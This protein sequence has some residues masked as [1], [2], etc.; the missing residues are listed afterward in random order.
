ASDEIGILAN[1]FNSMTSRLR[2]LIAGL[3]ERIEERTADMETARK[4]SE[5][6]ANELESISEISQIIASEQKLE[7]LLPL[8]TRLVSERFGFYHTGIFLVEETRHFAVLQAANSEGGRRM[9]A[10]GHRLELGRG[11]VGY[12]AQIGTHRI[13]L[14]VGTDSAYFNNPDL[15]TT[16]SEMALPLKTRSGTIGVLDVQ[17]EIANA[18]SESD[19]KNLSILADQISIALENTRL[20]EQTQQ[21]LN[22]SQTLYR[23]NLQKDWAAF[24][25]EEAI[26][27]YR[28][29]MKGGVKLKET[30]ENDE[31][32][33]AIN[34]GASIYAGADSNVEEPYIVV[35]IKLRGQAIGTLNVKAPT[36]D[37]QWNADE[38]DLVEAISERLS[39]ALENA[40]LIQESQ[41]QVV[42]QQTIRDMTEKISSSI[43]LKNV[44]QIAVEELGRVMPGSEVTLKLTSTDDAG[45]PS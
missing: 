39:I 45:K 37:R 19:A 41:R 36:Q 1:A 7:T 42:K 9:L 2:D 38:I 31:V 6:R 15:P 13:A 25:N 14:D 17:S 21:A 43:Y 22:E 40:R 24:M 28:Q 35:P 29:T 11:I 10:R 44:L 34:S 3:E 27:G 4:Q 12:V 20:F 26:I 5:K 18:F 8:I 33:R 16:R 30:V 32:R 23:Q